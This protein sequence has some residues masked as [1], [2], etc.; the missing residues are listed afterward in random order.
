MSGPGLKN[1]TIAAGAV[2]VLSVVALAVDYAVMR[3]WTPA[4]DAQIAALQE[5]VQRDAK[6]APVLAAEQKRIAEFNRARR[7]RVNW[8]S[9][10]L[11]GAAAGFLGGAKR[12]LAGQARPP[13]RVPERG[14][15][16][17]WPRAGRAVAAQAA[18]AAPEIDLTFVDGL[19]EKEGRGAEAAIPILQAIQAHYRYLPDE[20]LRRVCH[21][22]E[23]SPAQ[24]AGTSSFY[25]RFRRSPVGEHIV[26]VC[27]GT[28]CH[29]AGARQITDELRRELAI[30]EGEDTDPSRTFTV[31]EV[32]CLGC[33]SLAPVLMVDE[34]TAGKLT[35]ATACDALAAVQPGERA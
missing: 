18:A 5:K 8:L 31:E 17:V 35:P 9:L 25:S 11:V 13:V 12:L 26:R 28:A 7:A 29:V 21:L 10:V 2:M 24:I 32:A 30:A 3:G 14:P 34:H 33:C 4:S 23:I 1:A 19:I 16:A 6:L 27:H 15:S 20:A 22:T